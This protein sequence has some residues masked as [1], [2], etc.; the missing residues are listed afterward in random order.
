MLLQKS[1]RRKMF[2]LQASR[3]CSFGLHSVGTRSGTDKYPLLDM[4]G[5]Q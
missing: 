1:E 3:L 2:V 5:A 4:T